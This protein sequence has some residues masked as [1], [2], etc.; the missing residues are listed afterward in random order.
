MGQSIKDNTENMI[1][2]GNTVADMGNKVGEM[3][4]ESIKQVRQ[5]QH[6]PHFIRSTSIRITS[7]TFLQAM[8]TIKGR[9]QFL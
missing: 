6:L 3:E 8:V 2:L 7:G 5:P 4:E 1:N 9:M